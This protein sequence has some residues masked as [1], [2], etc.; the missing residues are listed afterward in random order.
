MKAQCEGCKA[1]RRFLAGRGAP[2]KATGLTFS[3]RRGCKA[4]WPLIQPEIMD[5][6]VEQAKQQWAREGER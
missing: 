6:R 1:L 3:H 4:R 2:D 5:M